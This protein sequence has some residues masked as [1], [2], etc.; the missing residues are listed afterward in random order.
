MQKNVLREIGPVPFQVARLE[1]AGIESQLVQE[2]LRGA[3]GKR[4]LERFPEL[5]NSSLL[6]GYTYTD[7]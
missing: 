5:L 4:V 1:S 6:M 7:C 2:A 3:G